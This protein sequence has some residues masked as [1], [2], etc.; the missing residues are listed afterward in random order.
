VF[1]LCEAVI[2]QIPGDNGDTN[3]PTTLHTLEVI[4]LIDTGSPDEDV[5]VRTCSLSVD[6]I[7]FG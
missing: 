2:E 5:N 7:L 6:C 1:P 3:V 4:T